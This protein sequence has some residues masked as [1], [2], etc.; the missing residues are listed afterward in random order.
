MENWWQTT[1]PE[2]QKMLPVQSPGGTTHYLAYGEIGTGKPIIFLHGIGSWSYS[3][4][5][6]IPILAENYRVIAFDLTGHGFSD[7][8]E[9][10]KITQLQQELPQVIEALCDEPATVIA[11]S[12]GGL[13]SVSAAIDYSQYFDRLVLINAA[14]FPQEL[15]SAGM[16]WLA[17]VPLHLV[18]G[19]DQSR[20]VKPLAPVVREVVRYARRDVV[21]APE[22]VTY[23]DVY[24]LTYPFVEKSGTIAHFTQ[25]LQQAAREIQYLEKQQPNL[26]SYVHD[27]L[28]NILCPTLILWGDSDRWF[29]PRHGEKLHQSLPNS[30]LEFLENCGHDATACASEQIKTKVI[31][32]LQE[33]AMLQA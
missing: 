26:I 20:L 9:Q 14:I 23:E 18:R 27:N 25:T 10:W 2:G 19:I 4:R 30:R 16:R 33:E 3:W 28:E 17:G 1:F 24:A 7:K 11:Q 22:M 31:Q 12:L 6:L 21:T 32:F 8:P 5:R 29:P 13:V 15:P